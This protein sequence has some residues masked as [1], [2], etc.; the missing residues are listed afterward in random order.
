[1]LIASWWACT[2]KDAPPDG[3][4]DDTE[5]TPETA[6][7][8]GD[9]PP[10]VT[11]TSTPVLRDNPDAGL[12]QW[13]DAGLSREG[14]LELAIE[15]DGLAWTVTSDASTSPSHLLL[16]LRPDSDLVVTVT[17]R[18][19]DGASTGPVVLA[20]RTDPLPAGMHTRR[21]ATSDPARMEPGVTL[22]GEGDWVVMLDADGVPCW[23]RS[24]VGASQEV[25]LFDG[26]F[27]GV[28]GL[29]NRYD[30]VDLAGT[31]V[32]RLHTDDFVGPALENSF[33]TPA[34]AIH[35]DIVMLP[36]GNYLTLSIEARTRLFPPGE[37]V[38]QA[39]VESHVAGE[40]VVELTPEGEVVG[41]W[42]LHDL[43]DPLRVGYDSVRGDYW[44]SWDPY[45][46]GAFTSDWLHANA[47]DYDA[48]TDTIL[49]S[50]R[51]QDALAA[52]S[53]STGALK[54]I[55][56]PPVNWQAAWQPLVLTPPA[57]PGA[58][59]YHQHGAHFTP[60]GTVLLFDNGNRRASA[61]QPALPDDQVYSRAMEL[62][63]D[64]G[65]GSWSVVWEW[66]LDLPDPDF[67]G[68][69]GGVQELP[70]T[71]NRLVTFGNL[72]SDPGTFARIYEVA[73][74]DTVVWQLDLINDAA[75]YR[76]VR[77]TGLIPGPGR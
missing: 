55:A 51:H 46:G 5:S 73:P 18:T 37:V 33:L 7:H 31:I 63:I 49:V 12:T 23:Y 19:A 36:N 69:L 6:G 25:D 11:F 15:I 17:G 76:S 59:F 52:L 44:E 72:S 54:W 35:H 16:G 1:M 30:E 71:G 24:A 4:T 61:F 53:R 64:E 50:M 22:I 39:P 56:A 57:D 48:A 47:L 41:E 20:D 42:P 14:W 75:W 38:P 43:M 28:Q 34:L 65:T 2:N 29:R 8:T 58:L 74:D 32:H 26:R 21:V 77:L 9:V 67:A 40:V 62:A 66:G 60:R 13:V 70:V 3:T 10:A 68:S 27:I 45:R